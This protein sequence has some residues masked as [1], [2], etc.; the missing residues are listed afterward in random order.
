MALPDYQSVTLPLLKLVA[1]TPVLKLSDAL[2]ILSGQF[3]L[4]QTERLE[5]TSSGRTKMNSRVQW[6]A[7]YLAQARC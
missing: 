2:D 6:A 3:A 4:T 5:Q 1:S 7:T